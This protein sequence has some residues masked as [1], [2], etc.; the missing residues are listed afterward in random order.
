MV[1]KRVVFLIE[2]R[3]VDYSIPASILSDFELYGTI[4]ILMHTSVVVILK[5]HLVEGCWSAH[6]ADPTALDVDLITILVSFHAL[7]VRTYSLKPS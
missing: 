4:R 5:G 1:R 3:T 6:A 7:V 2:T